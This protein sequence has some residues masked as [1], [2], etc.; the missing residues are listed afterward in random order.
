MA[1][2]PGLLKP[3]ASCPA[4]APRRSLASI[5]LPRVE[6]N[7]MP[8]DLLC[9]DL[10][11]HARVL[12]PKAFCMSAIMDVVV[13]RRARARVSCQSGIT[14][15]HSESVGPYPACASEVRFVA[16]ILHG[17]LLQLHPRA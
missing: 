10:C 11:L 15:L 2:L 1:L 4:A 17:M 12:L 3:G 14:A 5:H 7:V 13:K 8:C 6:N 9:D 16:P